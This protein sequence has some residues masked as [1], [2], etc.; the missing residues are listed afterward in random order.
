LQNNLG[1]GEGVEGLYGSITATH[2][3]RLLTTMRERCGLGPDSH[4]VDVGAGLGRPLLHALVTEGLAGAFGVE[5]D[6]IKCMKADA[7]LRQ[8]AIAAAR[9][10]LVSTAPTL[11]R[12]HCAPIEAFQTLDPATHAYSFWEGV[13]P[14]ARAA[15][16]RLFVASRT[17]CAVT[18][19]QRSLRAVDPAVFMDEA[20]GF[21]P[22]RLVDN[23]AVSMSGSGRWFQAYVFVR[24]GPVPVGVRSPRRRAAMA[25]ADG[26]ARVPTPHRSADPLAPISAEGSDATAVAAAAKEEPEVLSARK[27]L[28]RRRAVIGSL[29]EGDEEEEEEEEAGPAAG[30]GRG[31]K[32]RKAAAADKDDSWVPSGAAA[33]LLKRGGQKRKAAAEPAPP[34]L[35]QAALSPKKR[36][37]VAVPAPASPPRITRS[38]QPALEEPMEL[39]LVSKR[40]PVKQRPPAA[41]VVAVVPQQGP[42]AFVPQKSGKM[43]QRKLMPEPGAFPARRRGRPAKA[44]QPAP[45]LPL[46]RSSPRKATRPVPVLEIPPTV[47]NTPVSSPRKAIKSPKKSPAKS[48]GRRETR[49]LLGCG[50]KG[51]RWVL[52]ATAVADIFNDSAYPRTRHAL[53][54]VGA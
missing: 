50:L 2:M 32:G 28:R 47:A 20:Y 10:G 13:P 5:L 22:L 49:G 7:F 48:P 15:F 54:E 44:A 12:I 34:P 41:A 43:R 16:G 21:G 30:R 46:L 9:R 31:R 17:L 24:D 40:S 3:Q 26:D 25:A 23:F 11:P 42:A 1:G 18:V 33:G 38:M 4:L 35:P 8:T 36:T 51:E 37:R 39:P 6:A 52:D 19:V 14:E 53:R 45:P 29:F 27:S